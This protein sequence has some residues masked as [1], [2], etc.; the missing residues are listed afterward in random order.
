MK[1]FIILMSI[2]FATGCTKKDIF[3]KKDFE[4]LDGQWVIS[5]VTDS[6]NKELYTPEVLGVLNLFGVYCGGMLVSNN[7]ANFKPSFWMGT[8][9]KTI[10]S[11][12]ILGNITFD[13]KKQTLLL[14]NVEFSKDLL[15]ELTFS[16]SNLIKYK[17]LADDM[18]ATYTLKKIK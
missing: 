3:S 13:C 6:N 2:L 14:S 10:E 17:R 1:I 5:S 9:Y 11:K 16:S 7:G 18:N 15:L 4:Q 8:D 12:P